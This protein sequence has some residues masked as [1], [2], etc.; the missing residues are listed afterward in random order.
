MGIGL[1]VE[2]RVFAEWK[3]SRVASWVVENLALLDL[4]GT[5]PPCDVYSL[6]LDKGLCDGPDDDWDKKRFK[7][8][9]K[10]V[11]SGGFEGTKAHVLAVRYLRDNAV[12]TSM[13]WQVRKKIVLLLEPDSYIREVKQ[14]EPLTNL[15]QRVEMWSTTGLLDAVVKLPERDFSVPDDVFYGQIHYYLSP[16]EWCANIENASWREIAMRG[17]GILNTA[18][19]ISNYPFVHA[20]FLASTQMLD[21][22]EVIKRLKIYAEIMT[23]KGVPYDTV[24]GFSEGK[25]AEHFYKEAAKGL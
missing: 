11:M 21:R 25:S 12:V 10:F 15:T 1:E 22:D 24:S 14:R 16:A 3:D 5:V 2:S 20:S 4:A 7:E 8:S 13:D 18:R 17:D 6:S 9:P 23:H 19:I